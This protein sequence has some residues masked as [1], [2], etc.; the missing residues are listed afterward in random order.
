[1]DDTELSEVERAKLLAA[2]EEFIDKQSLDTE[3]STWGAMFYVGETCTPAA[4]WLTEQ[5][6]GVYKVALA[7]HS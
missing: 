7:N 2:C 6:E 1:M 4:K 5:F 3:A